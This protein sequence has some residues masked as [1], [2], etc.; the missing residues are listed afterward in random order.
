MRRVWPWAVLA[1]ACGGAAD[2][3]PGALTVGAN[4]PWLNYGHDFGEAWGHQG[5]TASEARLKDDLEAL[6]GAD[7]VRWF[8]FADGRALDHSDPQLLF[9]DVERALQL[10]DDHGLRVMPVLFDYLWFEAADQVDGV[11][12]FG[13][14]ELARGPGLSQLVDTWV[15][16]L[17]QR[18]GNDPRIVAVDLFNEPEWAVAEERPI[19]AEPVPH[20]EL[21]GFLEAVSAPWRGVQPLTVGCAS[22]QTADL[23]QPLDLDLVQI[24]HYG[25]SALPDAH[26]V[27]SDLPVWV[28]E[29]PSQRA[30]PAAR[31]EDYAAQ[32]YEGALVWSLNGDDDATDRGA[33]DAL[34]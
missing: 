31:I 15:A 25:D 26:E 8:V 1:M 20:S 17:A 10:A 22:W 33:V 34:F 18:F 19:V 4:L 28:G 2:V 32:G 29:F 27:S 30:D 23:W 16:P 21:L 6:E 9:A 12:I 14:S 5:V 13:R 24:H 3:E 7:V 11:Q